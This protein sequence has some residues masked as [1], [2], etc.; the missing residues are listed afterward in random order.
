MVCMDAV[1]VSLNA[2]KGT[3]NF[4]LFALKACQNIEQINILAMKC[5]RNQ[6]DTRQAFERE[7]IRFRVK[8]PHLRATIHHLKNRA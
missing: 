5:E 7:G 4:A 6:K 8:E 2:G 1:S 3:I